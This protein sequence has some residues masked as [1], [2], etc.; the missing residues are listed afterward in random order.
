MVLEFYTKDLMEWRG[1]EKLGKKRKIKY[2]TSACSFLTFSS[3]TEKILFRW[4]LSILH[5]VEL[6]PFP[7]ILYVRI[8]VGFCVKF[9]LFVDDFV[10]AV[11]VIV[12]EF[13]FIR[14]LLRSSEEQPTEP[15]AA[16]TNDVM[17]CAEL[18][19]AVLLTICE[20]EKLIQKQDYVE[21]KM[22][23]WIQFEYI[24]VV[25]LMMMMTIEAICM[26]RMYIYLYEK[27]GEILF[28]SLAL[29]CLHINWKCIDN[30]TTIIH[31]NNRLANSLSISETIFIPRQTNR[32]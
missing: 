31:T 30:T 14:L 1:R 2:F 11:V 8:N 10:A 4:K 25:R 29:M 16:A 20:G 6:F 27:S 26:N 13:S 7:F 23:R 21:L 24:N 5:Y 12:V 28:S 22:C 17:Y 19:R 18:S 9:L 32:R 3:L 15:T